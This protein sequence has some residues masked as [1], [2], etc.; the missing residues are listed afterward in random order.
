MEINSN[1][2]QSYG[3]NWGG[4]FGSS[5]SPKVFKYGGSTPTAQTTVQA[6]TVL[7]PGTTAQT[8]AVFVDF[9]DTFN[10]TST[11][12][13]V[14]DYLGG[15][16]G[17]LTITANTGTS[18]ALRSFSFSTLTTL[19]TPIFFT[20]NNIAIVLT[21]TDSTGQ[22]Y[23][24]VVTP[25]MSTPGVPTIGTSV[26]GV[27][28]D[29]NNDGTFQSTELNATMGNLYLSLT[30]VAAPVPEPSTWAMMGFGLVAGAVVIRRR[31][32]A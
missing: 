15:F 30:T 8:A 32:V 5:G 1:P 29:T 25:L 23:S 6:N 20:D 31:S 4:V 10:A 13:V 12:S 28:R 11:G 7:N 3:I 19:A 24:T 16:G 22:F 17:N 21:L 2:T 9:Y 18:T 27:Y 26:T 14:S